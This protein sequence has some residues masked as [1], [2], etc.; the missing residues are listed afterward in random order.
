MFASDRPAAPPPAFDAE[1][2]ELEALLG[3]IPL[4][5]APN[6]H[7]FLDFVCRKYFE[8]RVAEI[9]EYTIAVEALNRPP[10]FDP[11][12]DTIVRVT[13]AALRKRLEQYYSTEGAGHPMHIVLP[14]GNYAPRFTR[15]EAPPLPPARVPRPRRRLLV[16]AGAAGLAL[17]I[18]AYRVLGP[19]A[20]SAPA[21]ARPALGTP[22]AAGVPAA[23]RLLLGEARPPYVDAAGQSWTA[24]DACHGGRTF[25]HPAQEVQG[26]DDPALYLG[27]REGRF[28]CRLAVPPGTYEL[29]LY[30][31]DTFGGKEATRAVAFSLNGAAPQQL[32]VVSDAGGGQTATMKVHPDL[33]P[34]ADGA[35]HLDF[36]SD[37]SFLNALEVLPGQPGRMLPLRLLAGRAVYQDQGGHLW[38]PDRF[39]E[40][41][42]RTYRAEGLPK[43]DDPGLFQWERFGHFRYSLPV[44]PG[45]TYAVSLYFS[46]GW[47][48]GRNSGTGGVGSRVFDVYCNGTTL[49]AD[50]D[51]LRAQHDGVV[52]KTFRHVRPTAHGKLELSFTPVTNYP[53]INAIEVVEESS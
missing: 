11:R 23:V 22:A 31:A 17:A 41:G 49:L 45:R 50:F 24:D 9:K 16:V 29:H 51:I 27:G 7:R 20:R 44:V 32:D 21:T 39:F 47:F 13:A 52:V 40:G 30:F 4:D 6:L 48:G 12:S 33:Q 37:D 35:I 28:Q 14:P 34:L 36:L 46:E 2:R 42:R 38:L 15:A 53:L 1:K 10:D 18:L 3:A 43:V 26:T 25:R 5:R 19:D 8:G